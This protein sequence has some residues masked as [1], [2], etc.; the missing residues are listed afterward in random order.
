MK[1]LV[2]TWKRK[3]FSK[4]FWTRREEGKR[5]SVYLKYRG[6]ASWQRCQ[7][8]RKRGVVMDCTCIMGSPAE[9]SYAPS[10]AI[11]SQPA[12]LRS[13]DSHLNKTHDP[14]VL[15]PHNNCSQILGSYLWG[16]D[17]KKGWRGVFCVFCC[18]CCCRFTYPAEWKLGGRVVTEIKSVT[19]FEHLNLWTKKSL[20]LLW[21]TR[22]TER[23][24]ELI[25]DSSGVT[26]STISETYNSKRLFHARVLTQLLQHPMFAHSGTHAE[27]AAPVLNKPFL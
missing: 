17:S 26:I 6:L 13:D 21:E 2:E 15:G 23:K 24:Q 10:I 3:D 18:C 1:F 20:T 14:G 9:D 27:G 19:F 7:G 11:E 12:D 8:V 25:S 16:R 4:C 5:E 22:W